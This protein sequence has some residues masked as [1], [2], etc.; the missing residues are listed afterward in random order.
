MQIKIKEFALINIG[1]LMVSAGLYFFLM[2]NNLATGG[3]NGLAIVINK[4]TGGLSVGWIMMIINLILFV[5]AFIAIG[6]SFGGKSVYASFGVGGIIIVF[7][8]FIPINNSITGDIL[9]ELIFGILISGI[10]TAIVFD[11]NASTGGTDILAKILNEFFHI[12]LG[13]GVLI[14]DLII[15]LMAVFAFG[16]KLSLYAML[17]VIIN[18]FLIDHIIDGINVCKEVTIISKNSDKIRKYIREKLDKTSTV[19][20]GVGDFSDEDKEVV[21]V[22]VGRREFIT[23]KKFIKFVDK[24]AFVTVNNIYEVF[25]YGFKSL[26]H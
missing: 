3:A 22:I 16:I 4:F 25:G 24:D 19:Y 23:L 13:K 7:Q 14:C 5:I 6:K 15:I 9:L 18:G 11:Q 8:K 2:P 26:K 1:M 20:N 17:G 12:N 10:G 21:V